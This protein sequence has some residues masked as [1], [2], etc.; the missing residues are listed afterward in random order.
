AVIHLL[1]GVV[2][3]PTGANRR[4][5]RTGDPERAIPGRGP[6]GTEPRRS[7]YPH[8]T[9]R[10]A[11]RSARVRM[12]SLGTAARASGR[13]ECAA[14]GRD[15]Q[16]GESAPLTGSP[17]TPRGKSASLLLEPGASTVRPLTLS[18]TLLL[19]LLGGAARAQGPV[20]GQPYAIPQGY[21]GYS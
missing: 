8:P 17:A 3:R 1:E 15:E 5:A 12:L 18:L 14:A 6:S 20:P 9:A 21:E 11:N 4:P 13:P 7:L 2:N 19:G 16:S 10:H